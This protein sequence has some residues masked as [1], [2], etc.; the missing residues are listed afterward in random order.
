MLDLL[1]L[2][3]GAALLIGG[4]ELFTENAVGAA[5]AVGVTV[6][7]VGLLAAGAEPEELVTASIAAGKGADG[8]ALG[9]LVG[10]NVTI[11]LLA[12]GVAAAARPRAFDRRLRAYAG[13]ALLVS[14]PGAILIAT[15]G[16]GRWAGAGLVA[17]YAIALVAVTRAEGR[18]AAAAVDED[19]RGGQGRAVLLALAGVVLMGAG[20]N[21]IVDGAVGVS[22][23][24][25]VAQG[26]IGLTVV[27][28]ATSAELLALA[29]SEAR[30]GMTQLA[31]AAVLGSYAFNLTLG[32]GVAALV[33]PLA[34]PPR[35]LGPLLAML[36]A[37]A[38][39]VALTLGG[40]L[41]RPQGAVLLAGYAAY[42]AAVLAAA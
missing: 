30:R 29:W 40:R 25:G 3:L 39:L 34:S 22:D 11:C 33:S 13:G 15:G 21:F 41:G 28:L 6:L 8:I 7:A 20:G 16:V 17:L 32:L 36:A 31:I 1:V 23:A 35:F 19:G 4:A 37:P 42:V 14:V 18:A 38:L 10:T 2:G 5:R 27:A 26:P 9:D 24:L 12:L